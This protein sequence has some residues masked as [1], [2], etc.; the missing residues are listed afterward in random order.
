GDRGVVAGVAVL[1]A[2][3]VDGGP[4]AGGA[5]RSP[6]VGHPAEPD[7]VLTSH[8]PPPSALWVHDTPSSDGVRRRVVHP[9]RVGGSRSGDRGCGTTPDGGTHLLEERPG[10]QVSGACQTVVVRGDVG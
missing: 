2:G 8:S 9:Q 1:R 6:E 3:G 7:R 4:R 5:P 10:E